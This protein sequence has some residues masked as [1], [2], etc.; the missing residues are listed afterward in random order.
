MLLIAIACALT[1]RLIGRSE[2]LSRGTRIEPKTRVAIV[3]PFTKRDALNTLEESLSTWERF[4]PCESLSESF[5]EAS[6]RVIFHYNRD[7]KSDS[8]VQTAIDRAWSALSAD[9]KACFSGG[10]LRDSPSGQLSFISANLTEEEDAYPIGPCLQHWRTFDALR[11]KEFDAFDFTHWMQ[12]EPDVTPIRRGWVNEILR[13]AQRN[14]N[15]SEWWQ[16]GSLPLGADI[17][18]E[19]II[20]NRAVPDHHLNGNSLYCLRSAEYDEYRQRVRKTYPPM[21]CFARTDEGRVG[22]FDTA[23]YVYRA[24][25][26]RYR[27]MRFVAH[28]FRAAPLVLNYGSGVSSKLLDASLDA[29]LLRHPESFL[30]HSKKRLKTSRDASWR[31]ST[32][33]VSVKRAW[34]C[35]ARGCSWVDASDENFDS[36]TESRASNNSPVKSRLR[37]LKIAILTMDR[38]S[39]LRRLLES[40][41]RARYGEQLVDVH[42]HVDTPKRNSVVESKHAHEE[43]LRIIRAFEWPYGLK[44]IQT[45]RENIGLAESWFSINAED[46]KHDLLLILE[47]DV[48]VN[49][50][51]YDFIHFAINRGALND[52]N[53]LALCLHPGD[54]EVRTIPTCDARHSVL[55]YESPEPCNWGPVWK[56]RS[57]TRFV[58]WVREFR[59]AGHNPLVPENIAY[60]YNLYLRSALDVQSPWVWK[61]NWLHSSN[62]VR[63]DVK[64]CDAYDEQLYGV[65]NHREPGEHFREKEDIGR[66]A[67]SSKLREGMFIARNL[68]HTVLE[69]PPQPFLRA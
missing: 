20:R 42:I 9:T 58:A 54:W 33:N 31:S 12:L 57:W 34:T 43:I 15:C 19:F 5:P 35:G 7:L 8:E 47:D 39:S 60:N 65:I 50:D 55:F 61:Y 25:P 32:E 44:T 26:T 29:L 66:F 14:V 48:E 41:K 63:Y 21:G 46:A 68:S 4:A 67:S 23:S 1:A 30:V 49:V 37:R 40:L 22:G 10:R 38:P 11:G 62:H 64:R 18:G 69:M 27:E 24:D 16:L 59:A 17:R 3:I 13:L 45:R 36:R 6:V 51:F 52:P 28:K 2:T 56:V 53:N